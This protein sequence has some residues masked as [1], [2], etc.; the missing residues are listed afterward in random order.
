MR[1]ISL[2]ALALLFPGCGK[3]LD[4]FSRLDEGYTRV[5]L[6]G[7][8][9]PGAALDGGVMIIFGRTG[10]GN[11][12]SAFGFISA[13]LAMGRSVVVPN[14]SYKVLAYAAQDAGIL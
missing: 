9:S 8:C 13:E 3:F 11:G 1:K 5:E 6:V 12:G 4:K 2:L 14:G 10:A 7:D